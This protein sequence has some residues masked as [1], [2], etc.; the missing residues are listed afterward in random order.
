M[1]F[2]DRVKEK[3]LFQ[4]SPSSLTIDE[5]EVVRGTYGSTMKGTYERRPVIIQKIRNR[6]F[7]SLFSFE[8]WLVSFAKKAEMLKSINHPHIIT[9]FGAF[10]HADMQEPI[11]VMELMSMN[12]R[13]YL[14]KNRGVLKIPKQIHLFLQI[15]LGLQFLHHMTPPVVHQNLHDE[16]VLVDDNGLVKIG[17]LGQS[18]DC[19]L[20]ERYFYM[21]SLAFMEPGSD[22]TQ[23]TISMDIFA[24]GVIAVVIATQSHHFPAKLEVD[25]EILSD[26]H[27]LRESLLLRDT[28]PLWPLVLKCLERNFKKRPHIEQVVDELVCLMVLDYT[29]A[30]VQ[31]V[32]DHIKAENES[33]TVT[34]F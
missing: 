29:D 13:E 21:R 3:T 10:Y 2:S 5:E 19:K 30:K 9:Y 28:H 12:L 33:L 27:I 20:K 1:A 23:Y 32:M 26:I 15:A 4:V 25:F 18:N 24:L 34:V 22:N 14:E 11:L 16:S 6:A 31:D 17:G 8:D 7:V